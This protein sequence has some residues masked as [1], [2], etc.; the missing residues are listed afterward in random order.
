MIRRLLGTN[1]SDFLEAANCSLNAGAGGS[2][3]RRGD[4]VTRWSMTTSSS[5]FTCLDHHGASSFLD[6]L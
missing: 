6:I 1:P 2:G 3:S 5:R 4:G